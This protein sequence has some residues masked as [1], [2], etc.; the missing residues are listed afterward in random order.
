M[1][2]A[3]VTVG[4]PQASLAVALPR[5]A[6]IA[7]AVGLHPSGVLLPVA[8][9]TGAVLSTVQVAVREVVEL[10]PHASVAVHVLV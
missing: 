7:A 4:V 3:K 2:S 5:A 6:S 9:S 8:V 1:P 10:L